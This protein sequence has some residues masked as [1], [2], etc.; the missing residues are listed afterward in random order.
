MQGV[1]ELILVYIV[2]CCYSFSKYHFLQA[3][4]QR[5]VRLN[6]GDPMPFTPCNGQGRT[7]EPVTDTRPIY[8][9]SGRDALNIIET[10]RRSQGDCASFKANRI[11]PVLSIRFEN[12]VKLLGQAQHAIRI[13]NQMSNLLT[14]ADCGGKFNVSS[15]GGDSIDIARNPGYFYSLVRNT[16]EADKQVL[17]SGIVFEQNVRKEMEYFAPYSLKNEND[18]YFTVKDLSTTWGLQYLEFLEYLRTIAK[19]RSY[20]CKTV[21]FTPRKNQSMDRNSVFKTQPLVEYTDGLW[22][23]PYYQCEATRLWMVPYV[24]PFFSVRNNSKQAD[25][26]QFM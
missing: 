13:A 9:M 22:G 16:Y 6:A 10:V 15:C 4:L 3:Q 23:R 18:S 12:G 25:I 17:G 1:L 8:N 7:K 11:M 21:L 20:L 26:L 24:I 14:T 19:S 2:L 5:S